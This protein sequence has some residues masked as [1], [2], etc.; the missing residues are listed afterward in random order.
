M[1]QP[2]AV[3]GSISK[4]TPPHVPMGP[5]PFQKPPANKGEIVTASSNVEYESKAAAMFG[6]TAKMCCDPSDAPIG[7]V[8]GTAATVL[9]GG[10]GGGSDADRAAAAAAAMAAALAAAAQAQN[11]LLHP[12]TGHPVDVTTGNLIACAEDCALDG[13]LPIQFARTY[14]SERSAG[15]P[16][17]LG[18]GWVHN[19]MESLERIASD[20][21]DYAD[22][23]ARFVDLG[24]PSASGLYLAYRQPLGTVTHFHDVADGESR[25]EPAVGGRVARDGNE[26][27]LLTNAYTQHRFAR[28]PHRRGHFPLARVIDRHASELRLAYDD[29]GRLLHVV[30]PFGRTLRLSYDALHR[31]TRLDVLVPI[32]GA[33]ARAWCQYQYDAVGDLVA[34]KNRGGGVTG[35]RYHDHLITEER[36][37]DGYS[38]SSSTDAKRRCV[39]TWGEDGYLTRW[40]QYDER[41]GVTWEV[42][43]EGEPTFYRYDEAC[44]PTSIERPG[45]LTTTYTRDD[46]GRLTSRRAGP[47]VEVA[48]SYDDKGRIAEFENIDGIV[49]SFAYDPLGR[50]TGIRA[51]DGRSVALVYD[52]R[53]NLLSEHKPRNGGGVESVFNAMGLPISRTGAG[54]SVRYEYDAFGHLTSV[55]REPGASLTCAYDAFGRLLWLTLDDRWTTTYEWDALDRM[56]RQSEDGRVVREF[57]FDF[58]GHLLWERDAQGFERQFR[59]AGLQVAEYRPWHRPSDLNAGTAAFQRYRYDCE[60]RIRQ[61]EDEAGVLLRLDYDACGKT[62]HEEFV[63]EGWTRARDYDEAGRVCG[64]RDSNGRSCALRLDESGRVTGATYTARRTDRLPPGEARAAEQVESFEFDDTGRLVGAVA[65][66]SA[67]LFELDDA[68][69][70]IAAEQ[71]GWTAESDYDDVGRRTAIRVD[72]FEHALTFEYDAPGGRLSAVRYGSLV[73]E[74]EYTP[75]GRLARRR[76]MDGTIERFEYDNDWRLVA[77]RVYRSGDQL[78]YSRQVSYDE[79]GRLAAA[80]DS[81]RGRRSFDYQADRLTRID[82][83]RR[84]S[85]ELYAF[86]TRGNMLDAAG[87]P[88]PFVGGQSPAATIGPGGTT[89]G[90]GYDAKGQLTAADAA[91]GESWRYRYD[92]FGRRTRKTRV[93]GDGT[94]IA[95][96]EFLWDGDNLLAERYIEAGDD[97]EGA[98]TRS[99]FVYAGT[100][101]AVRLDERDGHETGAVVFHNDLVGAP[102]VCTAADDGVVWRRTGTA[103]GAGFDAGAVGQNLGYPGQ[104]WD[105]ETGLFYNRHRHYDPTA[106]RYLQA[107]PV[108]VNGGWNL[109]A[110]TPAPLQSSDLLGLGTRYTIPPRENT[111]VVSLSDDP[112]LLRLTSPLGQLPPGVEGNIHQFK[113]A[114]QQV[115]QGSGG[116]LPQFMGEAGSGRLGNTPQLVLDTHGRPGQIHYV[117]P[118]TGTREWINGTQLAQRLKARGFSGDRVV[119]VVCHAAEPGQGGGSVAQDLADEMAREP[120]ARTVEVIAGSGKVWNVGGTLI[121]AQP[122]KDSAGARVGFLED[123]REASFSSFGAGRPPTPARGPSHSEFHPP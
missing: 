98:T 10:G 104:Y 65:G 34:V 64:L 36:S 43:G 11:L 45:G 14:S 89:V 4:H 26:Y 29:F 88:S 77:T 37:A 95:R 113:G 70:V 9:I 110:Y 28:S 3:K 7:K 100:S 116:R 69:N 94:E 23:H 115:V 61:V 82:W 108:G 35:Y 60:G 2:G 90:L 123:A 22:V 52:E 49:T 47:A 85:D 75:D 1:G 74:R 57:G 66:E 59:F 91:G 25:F 114:T 97:G 16:G 71:D 40:L 118:T 101:P 20:H 111:Q 73:E 93:D 56:V 6:D 53:L 96:W 119:L 17:P 8:M 117:D 32:A 33:S 18:H 39:H 103:F 99:I 5:G 27:V 15:T 83:G 72:G 81:I 54:G 105:A 121:A 78:V 12:T 46:A 122:V 51:E 48:A 62:W 84:G 19:Y 63:A 58:A 55:R 41:R 30:D 109:H 24:M 92:A 31:L 50:C 21:A 67:V 120:N 106:A 68:G 80:E 107:D 13:P 112:N 44:R 79:A 102:D 42:N 86:D 76:G 38:F 87:R